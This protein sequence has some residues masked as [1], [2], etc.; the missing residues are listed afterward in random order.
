[1]SLAALIE[2]VAASASETLEQTVQA[3][4]LGESP[5]QWQTLT[6][7]PRLRQVL[8]NL[9]ENAHKYSPTDS[10]IRISLRSTN[11]QIELGVH[12][13]GIGIPAQE[14]PRV[15]ERFFRSSTAG[16]RTGSG[17]GLF[18]A[19]SLVHSLGG[20]IAAESRPGEGSSF[21]ISLPIREAAVP[22]AAADR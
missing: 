8:L 17:L 4:L 12:D 3:V 13:R 1:M 2:E 16:T 20:T 9:V 22:A 11:D 14:L 15:F 10:P 7:G 21:V 18:I 6:D 19:H 5:Q